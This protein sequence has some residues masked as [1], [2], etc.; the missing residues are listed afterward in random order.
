MGKKLPFLIVFGFLFFV[1]S[2]FA[3]TPQVSATASATAAARLRMRGGFF[4]FL[5]C[6]DDG[7]WGWGSS[8]T[9]NSFLDPSMRD[10][11]MNNVR[12][13]AKSLFPASRNIFDA[14]LHDVK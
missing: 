10:S 12:T 4:I 14:S 8:K 13:C 6:L 11:N 2:V 9:G 5:F 7:V 3:Q 1:P